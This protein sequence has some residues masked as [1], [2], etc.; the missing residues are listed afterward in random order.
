MY[1]LVIE[2]A[3]IEK[4]SLNRGIVSTPSIVFYS[5]N[6][7]CLIDYSNQTNSQIQS[8]IDSYFTQIKSGTTLN[9]F[10]GTYADINTEERADLTGQYIFR[11]YYNGIIEADVTS[12]ASLSSKLNRYDKTKFE[13]IPY[14][15]PS[16]LQSET[17]IK[18]YLKNKLGKNTKNS[19]NYLGIKVGDYIK[20]TDI[21]SQLK[22]M[23]LKTDSDGNEYILLDRYV[24]AI[25]LTN[26][27][28][29]IDIYISVVD[30]YT[31]APDI[32][33]T[34]TGTCTE[35]AN[36]VVIQCNNN[37]TRS[38]CRFRSSKTNQITTQFISGVF[39]VTPETNKA[40]QT[41]SADN[42]VQLTTTLANALSAMSTSTVAGVVN[43]K[44]NVKNSFYGRPF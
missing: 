13:Q 10:N 42:L 31:V 26:I 41:S 15:V 7:K 33:E 44:G 5:N 14:L 27:K 25:D 18:S 35:L 12:V 16:V 4:V 37:H 38:Q 1:G 21:T 24:E 30:P 8:E 3:K 39:C 28:T 23:E 43:N 34:E 9:L 36:N 19:F 22:V 11:S 6:T 32:S 17:E 2:D 20:I 40:I 29:K